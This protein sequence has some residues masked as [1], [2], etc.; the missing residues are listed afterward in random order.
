MTKNLNQYVDIY[1][2]ALN[3]GE[4]EIAYVALRKFMS[5][6][7]ATFI[8]NAPQYTCGNVFSGYM[9]YTY[10]YFYDSYLKEKQLRFG[11][12]LNHQKMQFELWLLG[13]NEKVQAG[14]WELLKDSH[15]NSKL[16]EKPIYSVLSITLLA[17]PDFNDLDSLATLIWQATLTHT[18]DIEDD[19]RTHSH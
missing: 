11:L 16:N 18:R 19:L 3:K 14:Y 7:R 4:I 1:K 12:V 5:T 13:R 6:L 10:F 15:W 9:D 17:D 2:K 8:K